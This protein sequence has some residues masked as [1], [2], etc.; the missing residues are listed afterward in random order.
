MHRGLRH[1]RAASRIAATALLLLA[2]NAQ[3]DP[4]V[5]AEPDP[6][7]F[8]AAWPALDAWATG[9]WWLPD[10]PP[11]DDGRRGGSSAPPFPLDVPRD[12]VIAFALYAVDIP[13]AGGGGTLKLTAQ[14]F[15][16]H[17][18]EPLTAWLEVDRGSGWVEAAKADV[19]YP[20]WDAHFRVSDWDCSHDVPYRVRHAGG[21][22]F[23]GTIRRDPRGKTRVTVAVMSCNSATTPGPRSEI[24]RSLRAADPDLLFFAGDQT[25]RHTQHTVG[26]IEFGLQ[27]RDVIRD[28]PTVTIPD[29]HDV[30]HPNLWGAGGRRSRDPNGADGGYRYPAAYVNMVQRQQTWHLPDPVDPAP[31]GQGIGVYFTRLLLGGLDLAI[32]ED[33]KFKTGPAGTIPQLGPRPDHIV[34]PTFDRAAVDLPGLQLLGGRQLDWLGRWSVDVAGIR[35]KAVLSQTAFCGAVHLHGQPDNRLL[36]DLDCNGWPQS[37]RDAALRLIKRAGAVHLCGD[38]HLA[39]VVQHG[40]DRFRDGPWAFT[41]PAL[42]NTV[43]GRWWHPED[44]LPGGDPPPDGPLPWTGDYLDGLGNRITM[45]AYANP[46]D[47]ADERRRGDG[48]GLVTWDFDAGTVTFHCFPRFPESLGAGRAEYPGWP[49]TVPLERPGGSAGPPAAPDGGQPEPD[50]GAGDRGRPTAGRPPNV[51]LVLVDDLGWRDLSCQGGLLLETPHID[52]LATAGMRFL[53]GYSACTVCSPTRAALLTGQYPARLHLTDWIAGHERPFAR[54]R[55]PPWRRGLPAGVVTVAERLQA[56]GYATASIGKW[57]L[58]GAGSS[59]T[60]RGFA[61][62]RGGTERGQPPSYFSPYGI[63]T[64][65]DGPPGEYLT[66]REAAEAV[67][68]IEAHRH[69][70]FFLHLAHHAVH[71]PLDAKADAI[72]RH[73]AHRDGQA[74]IYAA[75]I[76]GVDDSVGRILATLDRLGLRDSTAVIFTSDNGGN[77]AITD[78]APLRAGKGSAYEGGVRVPL[79]IS[80]PGVTRPAS[81][82]AVPTIT[83]D[84]AAT[85]LDLTGV[86]AVPGQPLDGVSLAGVLRGDAGDRGPL[87][88]HYPHYH[89]GGATPHSAVRAGD[90]RLVRFYEDGRREL[91]NL[92]ADPGEARDLAA[93]ETDRVAELERLLDAWLTTV[94][95]QLPEPNP[96]CDPARAAE[97]TGREAGSKGFPL[98]PGRSAAAGILGVPATGPPDRARAEAACLPSGSSP[99]STWTAA[100]S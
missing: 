87:Y 7:P 40:I 21:G 73:A 27:F 42:V 55:I 26:W 52:R 2:A 71:T 96:A 91:F 76:E 24:V 5:P 4:T 94:G 59:P 60:E 37:G 49:V 99:A 68:F 43:Y 93:V 77:L 17:P 36:A 12:E 3:A 85:I 75:M 8:G 65:R 82:S 19:L 25:Y 67:A 46:A 88:W 78:N 57:H 83:P 44:E 45:A 39:V 23:A 84:I 41:A 81:T 66:D 51:I 18:G 13:P 31:V 28:R 48:F 15:P 34:D 86:G 54:L 70:A 90:W 9:C 35:A 61:V 64:L 74:A 69:E 6:A 20:G 22:M 10:R 32:L 58:G 97:T 92:A 98:R 47:P 33:R 56:A 72:G 80:W 63:P 1:H 95:A 14:F 16:L 100:G 30:G 50:A 89:P 53:N 79:L 29:D 38:Q 11:A 62:N